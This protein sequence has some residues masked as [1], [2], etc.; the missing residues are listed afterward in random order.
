[1]HDLRKLYVALFS[2][3]P[4]ALVGKC[5]RFFHI[6]IPLAKIVVILLHLAIVGAIHRMFHHQLRTIVTLNIVFSLTRQIMLNVLADLGNPL[7]FALV[8]AS[9]E[10][11][12]C[13]TGPHVRHL[14]RERCCSL[15]CLLFREEICVLFM[16]VSRGARSLLHLGEILFIFR[17]LERI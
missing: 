13:V 4:Q 2:L 14:R 17:A 12:S 8:L 5:G 11:W 6:H 7:H 9:E 10:F 16:H 1:M 3:S 15:L